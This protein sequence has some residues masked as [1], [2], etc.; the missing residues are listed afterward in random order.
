MHEKTHVPAH[1]HTQIPWNQIFFRM[2]VRG[3]LGHK[4]TKCVKYAELLG[5]EVAQWLR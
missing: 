2:R 1:T 5:T 3:G 4:H